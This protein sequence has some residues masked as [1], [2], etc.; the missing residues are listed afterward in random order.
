MFVIFDHD[1]LV[2]N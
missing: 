2:R 1:V